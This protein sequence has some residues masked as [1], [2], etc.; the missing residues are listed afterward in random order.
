MTP[1]PQISSAQTARVAKLVE[2]LEEEL[3]NQ[4]IHFPKGSSIADLSEWVVHFSTLD[5]IVE[6]L[7]Y[8]L[9]QQA[10]STTQH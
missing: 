6:R 2:L 7:K 1:P 5:S 3:F 9:A 8:A 4:F 10:T